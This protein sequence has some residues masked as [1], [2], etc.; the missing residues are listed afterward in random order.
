[1]GPFS[2]FGWWHELVSTLNLKTMRAEQIEEEQ[3]A[4][5]LKRPDLPH[6]YSHRNTASLQKQRTMHSHRRH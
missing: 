2:L 4:A 3:K 5:R 6:A 1:M